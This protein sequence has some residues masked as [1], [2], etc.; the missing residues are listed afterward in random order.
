MGNLCLLLAYM[1]TH[2]LNFLISVPFIGPTIEFFCFFCITAS[3][4]FQGMKVVAGAT[5]SHRPNLNLELYD[6]EK[7]H[8]GKIV[9]ETMTMLDLTHVVFPC[10]KPSLF[11]DSENQ[12]NS[13]YRPIVEKAAKAKGILPTYPF[14][15]DRNTNTRLFGRIEINN[16][17]WKT[18]GDK[19]T[20]TCLNRFFNSAFAVMISSWVNLQ[21]RPDCQ[22]NGELRVPSTA[23]NQALE[24]WTNEG[25]GFGKK[26]R[27]VLSQLELKYVLKPLGFGA[28]KRKEFAQAHQNEIS[29]GRQS[30]G[31]VK[32]PYLFDP[33]TKKGMFESSEICKYLNETYKTGSVPQET[34]LDYVLGK[35]INKKNQE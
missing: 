17:L 6:F 9:R 3:R 7:C 8:D 29:S 34:Y 25:T 12:Q 35:K 2:V 10:P 18:Y 14:L 22:T 20:P 28:P 15:I 13:R 19:T 16:Y 21:C 31:L 23:P 4:G 30:V 33:N 32:H 1:N 27:E 5:E 26:C 24:L 11:K